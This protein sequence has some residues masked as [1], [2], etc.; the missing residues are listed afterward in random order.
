[1]EHDEHAAGEPR[2]RTHPSRMLMPVGAVGADIP[3]RTALA[4]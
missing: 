2:S 1:M 3:V 4:E